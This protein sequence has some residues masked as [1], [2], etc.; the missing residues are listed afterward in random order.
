MHSASSLGPL[1]NFGAFIRKDG[2][3]KGVDDVECATLDWVSWFSNQ[4]LLG[5]IGDRPLA[6]FEQM[7]YQQQRSRLV[8]AGVN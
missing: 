2:P 3:W 4:R 5:L 8:E 1:V 7:Y 6:E